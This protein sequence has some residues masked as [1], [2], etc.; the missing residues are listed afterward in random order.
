MS[1]TNQQEGLIDAIASGGIAVYDTVRD[2]LAKNK[3]MDLNYTDSD[4]ICPL[5]WSLIFCNTKMFK[6]FLDHGADPEIIENIE[7][8][9]A[10]G[11]KY[12]RKVSGRSKYVVIQNPRKPE[13]IEKIKEKIYTHIDEDRRRRENPPPPSYN[14][15]I[16][17]IR[18]KN[19][20]TQKPSTLG[21]K[22]LKKKKK[23]IKRKK[24]NSIKRKKK[25]S[26][27]RKNKKRTPSSIKNKVLHK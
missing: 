25:K 1:L 8:K 20:S 17:L 27:K 4:G 15:M 11:C 14:N 10:D 26:I 23:S 2:F 7:E 3:D 13:E 9:I 19:S 6:L 24:K 16:A 12:D 5:E 18:S 21:L 22:K